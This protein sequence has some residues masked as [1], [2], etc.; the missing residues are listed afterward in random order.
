MYLPVELL[1][2]RGGGIGQ[3]ICENWLKLGG[4]IFTTFLACETSSVVDDYLG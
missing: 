4:T 1:R 2:N 3:S